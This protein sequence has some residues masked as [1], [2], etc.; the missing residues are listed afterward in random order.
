MMKVK[1]TENLLCRKAA[2]GDRRSLYETL[3]PF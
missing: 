1:I 3:G 2:Y